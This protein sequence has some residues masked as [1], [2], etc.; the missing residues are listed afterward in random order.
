MTYLSWVLFFVAGIIFSRIFSFIF[1]IGIATE[2]TR[3]LSDRI[4]VSLIMMAEQLEY[5]REMRIIILKE[6]GATEEQIAF[7]LALFDKWFT[8]WKESVIIHYVSSYPQP[9]KKDLQFY[10]WDT[11]TKYAEKLIKEKRI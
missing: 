11:A 3:K 6:K 4:L 5:L 8:T 1:D 2:F 9:L 10:N 7:Q